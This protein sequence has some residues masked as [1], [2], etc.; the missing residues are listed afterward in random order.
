MDQYAVFGNPIA[1]SKSP[2]IHAMFAAQ[3]KQLLNYEAI[4]APLDGF[5]ETARQFF[6]AGGKGA[7]VTVP[8][9]EQAFDLA[10]ELSEQARL[11]GS[12]NTLMSN[13][14]K[15]FGDN[16]DGIGL[17]RDLQF[18]HVELKGKR[19]LLLGAG[20]AARGVILPLLRQ[21]PHRLHIANRTAE[22]ASALALQFS[23]YGDITGSGLETVPDQAFDV[24][25]NASSSGLSGERPNIAATTLHSQTTCYDMLY[26]KAQT[27]FNQWAEYHGAAVLLDGLGMLVEQAAQS[28][29]LWRSVQPDTSA[30]RQALRRHL[31]AQDGSR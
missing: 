20:G 23:E 25:I 7:N 11:A 27:P 16:T 12:V 26:G 9:K 17:V 5:E 21:S 19:I 4:L 10:D 6:A 29:S 30:V 14:G 18:H 3:T 2:F 24:I 22:K 31:Y 15:L 1:H 8:F 28:F 13:K